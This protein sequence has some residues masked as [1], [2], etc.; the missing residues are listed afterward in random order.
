MAFT[1]VIWT[2]DDIGWIIIGDWPLKGRLT[3][4]P[5]KVSQAS[6]STSSARSRSR[7]VLR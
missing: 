1:G 6:I 3:Y 7:S 2:V 4:S 5:A